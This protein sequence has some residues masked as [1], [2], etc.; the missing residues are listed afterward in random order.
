MCSLYHGSADFVGEAPD[1]ADVNAFI[2]ANQK[3]TGAL[4]IP[5]IE[6][7]FDVTEA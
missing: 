4:Q 2:A 5:G 6:V 7:A 3:Y 1:A